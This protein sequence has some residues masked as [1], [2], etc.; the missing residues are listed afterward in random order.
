MTERFV[1]AQTMRVNGEE[2]RL[3][4]HVAQARHVEYPVLVIDGHRGYHSLL[5]DTQD[6]SVSVA[7]CECGGDVE[8]TERRVLDFPMEVA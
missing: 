2:V 8:I 3:P 4:H 7:A 1:A 6:Q 5:V